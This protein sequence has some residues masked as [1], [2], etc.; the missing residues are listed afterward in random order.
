MNKN[1]NSHS[2]WLKDLQLYST[3]TGGK[4]VVGTWNTTQERKAT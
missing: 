1:N 2:K 3:A 4:L